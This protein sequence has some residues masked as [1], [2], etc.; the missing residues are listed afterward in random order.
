[1]KRLTFP[2]LLCLVFLPSVAS[3]AAIGTRGSSNN[4]V[5]VNAP[6]WN[7]FGPTAPVLRDYGQVVLRTQVV[8]TNQQAA[9]AID[10]Q[11]AINDPSNAPFADAGSCADGFYTY[12]FQ[13][14]SS[15][16]NLHVTISGLVGFNPVSNATTSTYGLETCDSDQ[17]TLELC[18]NVAAATTT[19]LTQLSNIVATVNSTKTAVTFCIPKVPAFP[20]GSTPS[21][22]QGLTLVVLTQQAPGVPV[23][24]PEIAIH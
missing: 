21:Q 17:N 6:F 5:D 10:A 4:G 12:L 9:N 24:V 2:V 22:G 19:A 18:S 13:I 14:K 16:T 23:F 8:C 1:M 3:F 15:A 20:A 7:L 11:A